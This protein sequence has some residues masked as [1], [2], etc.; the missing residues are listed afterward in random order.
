M[1]DSTDPKTE[2]KKSGTNPLIFVGIGCLV[3]LVVLGV[4]GSLI[5]RFLFKNAATSLIEG[6]IENKTGVK[7]NLNDIAQGKMSFTDPKTG[8]TVDIGSGKIPDSFP[9]DFPIYPG[10]KVT[11]ALAGAEKGKNSGFWIT[12]STSDTVDKVG[13]YYKSQ[14]SA[15]GWETTATYSAGDTSTQTVS[16]GDMSGSVAI[17]RASDAKE[18]EIVVI[19]GQDSGDSTSEEATPAQSE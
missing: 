5:G 17:T 10:A 12:L 4:A 1:A 15:K 6:A 3:L 11:S 2:T 7:T 13:A 16:K 19:V 18:T 14:L 9:K 8:S